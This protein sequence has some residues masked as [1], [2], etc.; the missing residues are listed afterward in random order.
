MG[1]TQS[2]GFRS[3]KVAA[4]A[5]V[6]GC[7]L[8][9][10]T[11]PAA[12][13]IA[14][15]TDPQVNAVTM[16]NAQIRQTLRGFSP[17]GHANHGVA[18]LARITSPAERDYLAALGVHLVRSLGGTA[19]LVSV[20]P[21]VNAQAAAASGLIARVGPLEP[22]HKMHPD[23]NA[24]L[25]HDWMIVRSAAEIEAEARRQGLPAENPDKPASPLVAVYVMIHGDVDALGPGFDAVTRHGG[26]VVSLLD[27]VNALV[28][29]M[30]RDRVA[31]LA[32][33]DAVMWIEPPLPKFS[34]TNSS[35]R[36]AMGVDAVNAAPYGRDGS[37]VTGLVYDAG[38]AYN[39]ADFGGR[40]TQGDSSGVIV[41][42][43]H[44]A[45]TIGGNGANSGG[46]NRG[47]APG[48]ELISYGFEV[49]GGLQPGFLYTDPG[50]FEHDYAEA[51]NTHGATI[52]NNSIGSNVESNGYPCPWQGDYGLMASLIDGVV[53]GSLGSPFRVVWAAGN[54]RQGTRCLG[55]DFGNHGQYYSVAPPGNAKNQ[56]A[57][58]A[59]NSNDDSMTSFSSWGPT[60]DGRLKPDVSGPGCQSNDDFGVTS[61][62]TGNGY[63]TLCG[64]SMAS[65]A[66]CGVSALIIEQWRLTN[67]GQP[68]M[69]NATLKA[70]LANSAVDR[71][72]PGP[73]FQF[74]Y[75]SVRAQPAVDTV[76]EGRVLET[77]IAQ[78][79]TQFYLAVVEPGQTELKIT[80]SWD[81]PPATPMTTNALINDAD[82]RIVGPDGSV[83]LP[84]TL[85]PANPSAPA[86]R[87]AP[88]RRN[89]TEQVAIAAPAPG[90]YRV[91]IT[92]FNIAQGPAQVVGLASTAP[93]F[94]CSSE[95][96][97]AMSGSRQGC[98]S[99]VSIDVVDC[100][101]NL[102]DGVPDTATVLVTS[103][104]EP[105][106]E[107]VLVTE[108]GPEVSVFNGSIDLSET[109]APGVLQV[110]EGDTMT[111]TYIDADDGHGGFDVSVQS[112]ADIDC[113]GPSLVSTSTPEVGPHS[114][115][116]DVSVSEPASVTVRYGTSCGA[117][118]NTVTSSQFL[119][120]HA[121]AIGGLLDDQRYYYTLEMT[122][123]AGNTA[124]ANNG[125]TCFTFTTP[126]VPDFMT[127]VF[128][129]GSDLV[130]QMV[131]FT[132]DGNVQD[133]YRACAQPLD[134]A[135]PT[136]P[137]GGTTLGLG[138]DSFA[139]VAVN[140]GNTVRLYGT[141]WSSFFVGSNGYLTFGSSD[142]DYTEELEDH[143]SK[144]RIAAWFD[145]LN[146][147]AAGTISYKRLADRVAVTWQNLPEWD[148]GGSNTF[149]IELFYDG[150]IRVSWL[151]MTAADGLV[152]LSRGDGLDPDFQP[153]DL[154]SQVGCNTCVPDFTGDGVLD[155]FDVQ[156][157]LDAFS[158]QEP[159]ADLNGD[160]IFD[161]F[162][163]QDYLALFSA[164]CP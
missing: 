137:A 153:S 144:P 10:A 158:A 160:G 91:E 47:M 93:L 66:V 80:M 90:A 136:N 34:T 78:G 9:L 118:T 60:D 8:A 99:T 65:P 52:A 46:T 116:L 44:V 111:V 145:D 143:F 23:L 114:A 22:R 102:D 13:Q 49:P 104:S 87:T 79:Q 30:P 54:E 150:T 134:G 121:I 45:G 3:R 35:A 72:N 17:A 139:S 74:G 37:G 101:L 106:G 146:P 151:A 28:V 20:D 148:A 1:S 117:L 7:G 107:I 21:N 82:L 62:S 70:I 27:S 109:D 95:G 64:T 138:D 115:L 120:D 159:A 100:D 25:T 43:T 31:A 122:D 127:E 131:T 132:T 128:T 4:A 86:V 108:I 85:N 77:E 98:S 26:E 88:D 162:D 142:T 56:I 59:L 147:S 164:G 156:N 71:G 24:G 83:H 113:T 126:D 41:H 157:F 75:G 15:R 94:T 63:A 68:D 89:N 11:G 73:D 5:L 110:R 36:A 135:L 38:L 61:T 58:G 40:L 32:G 57:V 81:D 119:T 152:G 103:D 39:H 14:W 133:F 67:S 149:Q 105:A 69:R 129:S 50:D 130:G 18:E 141:A 112:S 96:I 42:S 92:G 154:S 123:E 55:D 33:E 163:V 125:G 19:Y 12:G 76:L 29:H 155:F 53:G 161:F 48:V 97:V 16:T 6:V 2:D 140:N 51:I 84:W 124:T